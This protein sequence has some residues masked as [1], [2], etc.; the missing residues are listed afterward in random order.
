[1]RRR[2]PTVSSALTAV[3]RPLPRRSPPAARGARSGR[4]LRCRRVRGVS[5]SFRAS[6]E[7]ASLPVLSR[8]NTLPRIVP[9]LAVLALLVGGILIPGWGWVLTAL[10][11]LFLA[12][13]L[14]LGWPRLTGVER[15]MRAAVVLLAVAITVTQAVPRS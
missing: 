13:M 14:F 2:L 5:S 11:A 15:L 4:R 9:F 8:L 7:R 6:V 12:W 3:C 1:M 10:V